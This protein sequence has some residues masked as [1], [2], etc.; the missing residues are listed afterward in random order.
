MALEQWPDQLYEFLNKNKGEH[1]PRENKLWAMLALPKKQQK[2]IFIRIWDPVLSED[3]S[4]ST[5]L[6]LMEIAE[7]PDVFKALQAILNKSDK[8]KDYLIQVLQS[9]SGIHS[10]AAGG[11]FQEYVEKILQN[12]EENLI[13]LAVEAMVKF[14]IEVEEIG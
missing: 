3:I 8:Q 5:F 6:G 2:E 9:H 4:P 10:S 13:C 14:D 7:H 11:L 12:K 1:Y